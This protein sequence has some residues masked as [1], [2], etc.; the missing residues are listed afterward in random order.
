MLRHPG[1]LVPVQKMRDRR[2]LSTIL[3]DN[4]RNRES[5]NL[6]WSKRNDDDNFSLSQFMHQTVIVDHNQGDGVVINP[7]S[8]LRMMI[9]R[10]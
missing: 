5:V 9:Q 4:F 1:E 8:I 3:D 2:L 10:N 6:G 7:P